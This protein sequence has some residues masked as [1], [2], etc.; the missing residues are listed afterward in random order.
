MVT[1]RIVDA[2]I[3]SVKIRG[4]DKAESRDGNVY[5]LH[6]CVCTT[7]NFRKEATSKLYTP[8]PPFILPGDLI[9]ERKKKPAIQNCLDF[10][11]LFF[12]HY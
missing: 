6:I 7:Q 12:F 9:L 4:V 3:E 10:V 1:L 5:S 8:N 2:I 11:F